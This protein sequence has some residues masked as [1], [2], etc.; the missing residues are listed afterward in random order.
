VEL[1]GKV[2]QALDD[3]GF[4]HIKII[5]SSGFAKER[6]VID[7]VESEELW[8]IKL[9]DGLGCGQFFH[10][11]TATADIVKVDGKLLSKTGRG[12]KENKRL[13]RRL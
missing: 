7:F 9:F 8:K 2:R 10:S 11:R 3:N 13:V 12:Y 1:A 6:K 5:L 4:G